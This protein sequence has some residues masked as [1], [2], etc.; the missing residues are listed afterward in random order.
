M[1]RDFVIVQDRGE[2]FLADHDRKAAFISYISRPNFKLSWLLQH[3]GH[4]QFK[5]KDAKSAE[6]IFLNRKLGLLF[7]PPYGSYGVETILMLN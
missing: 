7:H 6:S 5:N 4:I 3:F 2:N 1:C